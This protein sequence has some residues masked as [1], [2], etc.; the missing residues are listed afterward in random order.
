MRRGEIL[1]WLRERRGDVL[2]ELWL[3]ANNVR[4]TWVGNH[5]HLRG[6]LEISSHCTRRCFYCG[7]RQPN[8]RLRRY[9]MSAA[10]ILDCA[11]HAERCG[12]GTVVLQAGEE[13][14]IGREWI[15]GVIRSIKRETSLAVTLSLGERGPA[16]LEA[17]R[18][19]G[20]DRY[21]LRFESSSPAL[22]AWYR[23]DA[24]AGKPDRPALLD[25]LRGL[26]YE[27]G[28][29]LL[30]GLPGQTWDILA[31]DLHLLRDLGLDMIGLGPYIAHPHTPLG[32]A[33]HKRMACPRQ[34]VPADE[35]TTCKV[36]A[37]A[38]ILCPDTNIPATTAL[39]TLDR[40]NGYELGLGR[41]ANVIMPNVTPLEYRRLYQIYPGKACLY[42][43]DPRHEKLA[44]RILSLGRQIGAGR[45]DSPHYLA[46]QE[47]RHA[48]GGAPASREAGSRCG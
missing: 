30:V 34:Q 47:S 24:P 2:G 17:W 4:R 3:R 19:A 7:L 1:C 20:A 41:G 18:R 8:R 28:S 9:R 39:A 48:R 15:C 10:E 12:F 23:P 29:G 5:V 22:L 6:L 35:L 26:G 40:A 32:R 27:I 13:P 14:G 21:L 36:I 37:L 43:D 46:R 44:W 16:E 33:G 11:R 42:D 31:D 45:G 38:R 25:I